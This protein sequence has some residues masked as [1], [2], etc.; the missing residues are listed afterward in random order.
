M[1]HADWQEPTSQLPLN[2]GTYTDRYLVGLV[3]IVGG[4][5]QLNGSNVWTIP[6]LL[7]GTAVHVLGWIIL[8]ARGWRRSLAAIAATGAAVALLVGPRAMPILAVTL[9]AWL[10][11]RHRPLVSYVTVILPLACGLLVSQALT[12]Y[13]GMPVALLICVSVLVASA[14]LARLIAASA[15]LRGHTPSKSGADIG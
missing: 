11:V 10:L 15:T 12:A 5:V 1:A 14:W 9:I 2:W 8:P 7:L 6:F 4:A 13:S 3:L